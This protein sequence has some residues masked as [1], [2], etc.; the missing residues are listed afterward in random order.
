MDFR[1]GAALPLLVLVVAIHQF[2]SDQHFPAFAEVLGSDNSQFAP[3]HDL[4]PL[5]VRHPLAPGVLVR[6]CLGR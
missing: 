6:P 5:G 2:S 1:L 4:M 3:G